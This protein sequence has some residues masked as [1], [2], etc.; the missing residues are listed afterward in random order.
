MAWLNTL[1]LVVLGIELALIY[2][3]MGNLENK[4]TEWKKHNRNWIVY[5]GVRVVV[6]GLI[7]YPFNIFLGLNTIGCFS[8]PA[9]GCHH[10]L[11]DI[12][13]IIDLWLSDHVNPFFSDR[14]ITFAWLQIKPYWG[15]MEVPNHL[16]KMDSPCSKLQGIRS[17]SLYF[18]D[19][20]EIV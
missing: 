7:P 11:Y 1:I 12:T 5:K 8:K 15:Y 6:L 19:E 10:K 16:S 9:M 17:A 14:Q 3:R 2:T 4:D 20:K 13:N 18:A